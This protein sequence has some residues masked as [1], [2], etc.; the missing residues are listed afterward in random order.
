M[1]DAE[2]IREVVPG[3]DAKQGYE[4]AGFV[5]FQG[6]NDMCNRHYIER[7]TENMIHFISDVRKDLEAPAMPFIVGILGVYGTDPDSRKF[8]E[9][10]PVT[11]FRKA[12]FAAV[13]QYDHEAPARYRGN[14]IAVD[15]G[16]YYE[17]ELSD[18]Y[19]KRRLTGYWRRRVQQ[20]EMRPGKFKEECVR[21]AFGD[22]KLTAGE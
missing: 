5:W 10:L 22:G 13:E 20:G 8:D 6:W 7:Y 2:S 21:H 16:P 14:V 4:L 12:Q 15:S 3:Y 19:C 1:R 9:G 18:I 11:A 17:L